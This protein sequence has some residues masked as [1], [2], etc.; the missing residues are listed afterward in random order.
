MTLSIN[1]EG[2]TYTVEGADELASE[3]TLRSL[4]EAMNARF[5]IK[6]ES[7]RKK[8]E[9]AQE[10]EAKARRKAAEEL[11]LQSMLTSRMNGET[12][13]KG[14]LNVVPS[15]IKEIPIVGALF[16]GLGAVVGA[17]TS[18]IAAAWGATEKVVEAMD[19]IYTTGSR[20]TGGL[21][22]L[23]RT[24]ALA[25][26]SVSDLTK[27]VIKNQLSLK[28]F[29]DGSLVLGTKRVL[30]LAKNMAFS[31]ENLA[32]LGLTVSQ[33][34]DYML[35]YND[36]TKRVNGR[37]ILDQGY[38][39]KT[40]QQLRNETTKYIETL[41]SLAN[42]TGATRDEMSQLVKELSK[43]PFLTADF[44]KFGA[45]APRLLE[46]TA[47]VTKLG[48]PEFQ[49]VV[50]NLAQ[51]GQVIGPMG[52][53]F[54]QFA[55]QV[56]VPLQ[57]AFTDV[58]EHGVD[59]EVALGGFTDYLS[60]P[61]VKQQVDA[62]LRSIP[63]SARRTNTAARALAGF[64]NTALLSSESNAKKF[65]KYLDDHRKELGI[66][67]RYD[68]LNA[69]QRQ[70]VMTAY[71]NDINEQSENV[72]KVNSAIERVKGIFATTLVKIVENPMFEKAVNYLTDVAN[73][74][75]NSLLKAMADPNM[76]IGKFLKQVWDS[77]VVALGEIF[78]GVWGTIKKLMT[79]F[80]EGPMKYALGKII[81]SIP[82]TG[83]AGKNMIAEAISYMSGGD[84]PE[85]RTRM[86]K[87]DM[88]EAF[89]LYN[90]ANPNIGTENLDRLITKI[91]ETQKNNP[92][93]TARLN[94]YNK[95][96]PAEK[97]LAN[98]GKVLTDT[99]NEIN[100]DLTSYERSRSVQE[101]PKTPE[102]MLTPAE[103]ERMLPPIIPAKKITADEM[104]KQQQELERLR[105]ELAI[106]Q[107]GEEYL[108]NRDA[109]S[110]WNLTTA[111]RV[112]L[113][114][115]TETLRQ[116]LEQLGKSNDNSAKLLAEF[117]KSHHL[118]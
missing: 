65:A 49:E 80:F 2:N 74:W 1:I 46:F 32:G 100:S 6:G 22:E 52:A 53:A 23:T 8:L 114:L 56:L 5:G 93:F 45:A 96:V 34:A 86:A 106:E 73:K 75:S 109:A 55:P 76:T 118:R 27:T 89:T 15:L 92:V 71:N 79:D 48:G 94:E 108:K 9:Q 39:I 21:S 7:E 36:I 62:A 17:F 24:A 104:Q 42:T 26:I 14:L 44:S 110:K 28:R 105:G 99:L 40:E 3:S 29:G 11:D 4:A 38:S 101:K 66:Q 67:D 103:L 97:T 18:I 84:V 85:T 31:N 69:A 115:Q 47:G 81:Q 72:K 83:D 111:D 87:E 113:L 20:F 37:T 116:M 68:Q 64:L 107:V 33:V 82:H 30:E 10:R 59:A 60:D 58:A 102:K 117:K 90:K 91:K 54:Q 63:E 41:D 77:T 57:K 16:S 98:F 43:D 12:G 70:K 95:L 35:E 112:P 78:T 25:G 13:F 88:S 61:V 19:Q 50:D 51:Y